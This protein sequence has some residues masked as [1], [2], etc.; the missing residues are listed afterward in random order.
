M[1]FDRVKDTRAFMKHLDKLGL[2]STIKILGG[3]VNEVHIGITEDGDQHVKFIR[4][5]GIGVQTVL[6][7][8]DAFKESV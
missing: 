2:K 7:K 4:R 3:N 1:I 8:R 5:D 6:P